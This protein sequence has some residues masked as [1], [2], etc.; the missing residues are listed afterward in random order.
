MRPLLDI[1]KGKKY[2]D[3]I[4]PFN[5]LLSCHVK[6]FGHPVGADPTLFHLIA[7]YT[8]DPRK[9]LA[10]PWIDQYSGQAYQMTTEGHHGTR[11]SVRVKTYGDVLSEYEFHPESKCADAKGKP[12]GKQTI[13]LLQRRHVQI[14]L[15]KYIGKESNSL[16][17]VESGLV[18]S[19]QNVY[20][21]Y[22]DA[23]RDE[24]QTKIVPALQNITIKKLQGETG[25]SRRM[26][27]DARLGHR[28]PH[29]KNQKL[30]AD[31]VRALAKSR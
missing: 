29:Q 10:N 11:K 21:E 16:E 15:I 7:P 22:P 25:L 5:F 2:C 3:Q 6:Q 28:R 24:W 8:S 30:L 27:I 19:A 13:G 17:D 26:L 14:D 23:R 1:N 12:C 20:T 9:W 4:K 31:V 18:H